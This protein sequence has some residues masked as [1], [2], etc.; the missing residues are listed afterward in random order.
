[1]RTQ[2]VLTLAGLLLST[3][4][5]ADSPVGTFSRLPAAGILVEA[6]QTLETPFVWQQ[7][8]ASDTPLPMTL[9]G[10]RNGWFSGRI[11]VSSQTPISGLVAEASDL[12][13]TQGGGRIARTAIRIRYSE[14]EDPKRSFVHRVPYSKANVGRF[15][16][17]LDEPPREVPVRTVPMPAHMKTA[18]APQDGTPGAVQPVWVTVKVPADAAAGE[19]RGKI[20]VRAA[21]MPGVEVPIHLTVHNWKVPDPADFVV[22]HNIYQSHD[23]EAI[24]YNVPLWSDRHFE[25]MGRSLALAREAGNRLCAVHLIADAFCMGN[26]QSMVRW[27][28][29]NNGG[30]GKADGGSGN[31]E[32]GTAN[33]EPFSYD[34]SVFDRYLDLFEKT[35]GKPGVLLV[36]VWARGGDGQKTIYG[37][38]EIDLPASERRPR[39]KV[40][41]LDPATGKVEAL[42]QPEYGTPESVAF[43]RPVLKEV[44]TRLEKRGW[45]DVAALGT[46]D[47]S[48]P[49]PRTVDGFRQI[50]P[51]GKWMSTSHMNPMVYRADGDAKVPVV[52]S[53]HVWGAGRLYDPDSKPMRTKYGGYPAPWERGAA[54]TEWGHPRTGI[55]FVDFLFDSSPLVAWRFAAEGAVQGNLNGVGRIGIDF[56]PIPNRP[57]RGPESLAGDINLG[58]S[59]STLALLCRGPDG[60]VPTERFEIFRE[61][62]QIAEAIAC[63]RKALG[64]RKLAEDVAKRCETLL[65]DRARRYCKANAVRKK[66]GDVCDWKL[67]EASGWQEC[68]GR[69]FALAGEISK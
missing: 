40:T 51:D 56:W 12:S 16:A 29:G 23:S 69:L 68:D 34:F 60:A 7:A 8:R 46:G 2:I 36:S 66:A 54:R 43:W 61:G 30:G 45:F 67:L 32:P 26:A 44:R 5:L 17:L 35:S 49:L 37:G 13:A 41:L 6:L 33:R 10:A 62:T 4:V 3:D 19:Y 11:V 24:V 27:I 21:G 28:R 65:D 63:V 53:E 9:V 1:M 52:Y 55:G 22:R 48:V 14:A 38:K 15:D 18:G 58:P 64:S 47:D 39:Q 31:P 59:A 20:A 50:W 42:E 57:P 25:L